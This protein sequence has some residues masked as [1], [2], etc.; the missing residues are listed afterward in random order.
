M[1]PTPCV[2]YVVKSK[3]QMAKLFATLEQM[4][5]V[6]PGCISND[7]QVTGM[8]SLAITIPVTRVDVDDRKVRSQESAQHWCRGVDVVD[9]LTSRVT[10]QEHV[11][12]FDA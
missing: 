10:L 12:A 1:I 5:S 11:N 4:S 3:T 2:G 8:G 9:V 7:H 6:T